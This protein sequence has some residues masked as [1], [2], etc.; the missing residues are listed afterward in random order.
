MD[1]VLCLGLVTTG[2]DPHIPGIRGQEE[3]DGG[4]V[5]HCGEREV[6]VHECSLLQ[7]QGV[8]SIP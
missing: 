4:V 1:M 3:G 2:V 7:V 8:S 6:R 5:G